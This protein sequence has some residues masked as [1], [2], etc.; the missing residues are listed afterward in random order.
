MGSALHIPLPAGLQAGLSV[1][2]TIEYN[3]TEPGCKALQWLDKASV[4][5]L[6]NSI[7]PPTQAVWMS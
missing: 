6:S 3:T 4:F 5:Q 1:K 2:V 7:L